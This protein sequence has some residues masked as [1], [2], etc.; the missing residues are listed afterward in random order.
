LL[1]VGVGAEGH[2]AVGVAGSARDGAPVDAA[3]DELG[4]HEVRAAEIRDV[5]TTPGWQWLTEAV[6]TAREADL[7]RRRVRI[8]VDRLTANQTTAMANFLHW[9][10][11]RQGS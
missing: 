10:T 5:L 1:E 3:G 8:D 11:H 4:N 2:V 9:P 6:R 7:P